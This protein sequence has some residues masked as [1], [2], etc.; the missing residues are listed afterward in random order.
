[1]KKKPS[2]YTG[3]DELDKSVLMCKAVHSHA[4][5]VFHG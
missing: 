2:I 3:L 4:W 5:E 1:M